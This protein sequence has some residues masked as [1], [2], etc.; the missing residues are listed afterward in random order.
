MLHTSEGQRDTNRRR[1]R[2]LAMLMQGYLI[3][4][5][6]FLVDYDWLVYGQELASGWQSKMHDS[7]TVDV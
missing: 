6:D 4:L 5:H 3:V 1:Q 2:Q 7:T